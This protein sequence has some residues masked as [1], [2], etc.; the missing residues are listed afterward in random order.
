MTHK[1]KS[2][3]SKRQPDPPFTVADVVDFLQINPAT[4]Q[5]WMNRGIVP[6]VVIERGGRTY[7]RFELHHIN[8]IAVIGSL[9]WCGIE[10]SRCRKIADRIIPIME[11]IKAAEL[12]IKTAEWIAAGGLKRAAEATGLTEA[13]I[14]EQWRVLLLT[15]PADDS[16]RFPCIACVVGKDV[17]TCQF[18][19]SVEEALSKAGTAACLLIDL[20]EIQRQISTPLAN[21]L[22]KIYPNIMELF[23]VKEG[24]AEGKC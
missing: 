4:F 8:V 7:R 13:E 3:T 21:A 24:H 23:T 5:Q 22:L 1:G 16:G 11:K 18:S 6:F 20:V 9:Y 10:P 17:D 2:S 15:G 12:E 14:E 19:D